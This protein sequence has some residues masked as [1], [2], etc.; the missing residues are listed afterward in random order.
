VS[1]STLDGV[2]G[3]VERFGEV[4]LR[5]RFVTRE[6]LEAALERQREIQLPIGE[7]LVEMGFVTPSQVAAILKYQRALHVLNDKTR[8]GDVDPLVGETL[9]GCMILEVIGSGAMGRAYKA[10]HLKLDR[11]VCIK[12]LHPELT[13][14]KRTQ[15]RFG[16]EARAA[17][18]LD[19]PGIVSVYDYDEVGPYTYIVMQYVDGKSLK[20]VLDERGAV[21]PKRAV[22][23]GARIAEALACAHERG[24]VHRDVKPANVLVSRQGHVKLADFGLVRVITAEKD[25]GS[26]STTGELIGTPVY[27]SPEQAQASPE[28]DG[29]ADVYGLGVLIYELACGRAPFEANQL[30]ALLRKHMLD[31]YPSLRALLPDCP[32]ALDALLQRAGKKDPR[33]RPDAAQLARELREVYRNAFGPEPP[34]DVTGPAT[35]PLKPVLSGV[36]GPVAPPG[37]SAFADHPTGFYSQRDVI[38][39]AI[40]KLVARALSGNSRQ[41]AKDTRRLSPAFA[42]EAALRLLSG[43]AQANKHAEIVAAKDELAPSL[44]DAPEALVTIARSHLALGVSATAE[45]LLAHAV[46]KLPD[47]AGLAL[48]LAQLQGSLGKKDTALATLEALL[49]RKAD[50]ESCRRAAE[51][52]Y[53]VLGDMQGAAHWFGRSADLDPN[54]FEPRQQQGFLL[55]E[56]GNA[57]DAAKALEDAVARQ[58]G[59]SLAHELLGKARRLKGD[60]L[61]STAALRRALDLDPRAIA[62]RLLLMEEARGAK[63]WHDVSRFAT[64]GL[65]LAPQDLELQFELARARESEGDVTAARRLFGMILERHPDHAAARAAIERLMP[66]TR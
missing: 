16:R 20:Q 37:T 51:I 55:L 64:E 40:D 32:P 39:V 58:P 34:A 47:D 44:Q 28:I 63:R 26:S 59:S 49:A 62:A 3:N 15:A 61:G 60:V 12:V 10:H 7:V 31:P 53:I 56:L 57:V 54:A 21:G 42:R 23:I 9:G 41:A 13:R 18:K 30:V 22:F 8:S 6:Q 5:Q 1:G 19:H 27:M 38:G 50:A 2:T 11:D 24:I 4:A 36:E 33:A 65:A 17:A 25:P 45:E 48:E 29:R 46:A 66:K 14:D 43:L 52:R 35:T